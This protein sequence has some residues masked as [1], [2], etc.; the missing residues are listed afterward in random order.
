M[1]V[2]ECPSGRRHA[3]LHAQAR[4]L[5]DL[6]QARAPPIRCE[7]PP[8]ACTRVAYG[9]LTSSDQPVRWVAQP[10]EEPIWWVAHPFGEAHQLGGSPSRRAHQVG[11]PP[12]RRSP[13][14]A[15]GPP[16]RARAPARSSSPTDWLLRRWSIRRPCAQKEG[17]EINV[18][19]M[20]SEP[21]VTDSAA[22]HAE[23]R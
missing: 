9:R 11:A 22:A 14:A 10:L 7:R 19:S 21:C 20:S 4:G 12:P 8:C 5:P 18:A 2:W 1:A 17:Q 13:S 16:R 15:G 6:A 3:R 23:T